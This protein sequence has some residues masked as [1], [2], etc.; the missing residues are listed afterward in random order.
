M[1]EQIVAIVLSGAL[2]IVGVVAYLV[3]RHQKELLQH[4]ER[5]A[6]LEKGLPTESATAHSS[7][8]PHRIYFLRG[9]IWLFTGL[10]LLAFLTV[11]F[12]ATATNPV[13]DDLGFRLMHE[14]HLRE[15]G[16]TDE[17]VRQAMKQMTERRPDGPPIQLG[18]IGLVPAAVGVA[19]L[20]FYRAEQRRA[21]QR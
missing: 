10:A 20:L 2:V 6:A 9:M 18:M 19:Y 14:K 13:G 12:A 1:S 21:G 15:L 8:P 4:R 3:L 7:L 17:Q 5:M 11:F 16:A